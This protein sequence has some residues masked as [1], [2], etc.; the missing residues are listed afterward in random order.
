MKTSS[1]LG[2]LAAGI[3]TSSILLAGFLWLQAAASPRDLQTVE[4][5]EVWV[6]NMQELES[7]SPGFD[8]IPV[9]LEAEESKSLQTLKLE[10]K[11][12][13]EQALA[14]EQA[15]DFAGAG[16]AARR[17]VDLK[18]QVGRLA[19]PE[20]LTHEEPQWKLPDDLLRRA[21]WRATYPDSVTFKV[22]VGPAEFIL[23]H[24]AKRIV[25]TPN[26]KSQWVLFQYRE[27]RWIGKEKFLWVESEE[28]VGFAS[29]THSLA[30]HAVNPQNGFVGL[31]P[32]RSVLSRIFYTRWRQEGITRIEEM[33]MPKGRRHH[34]VF[35][36]SPED[37]KEFREWTNGAE[38]DVKLMKDLDANGEPEGAR[39]LKT[40]PRPPRKFRVA[41]HPYS[42]PPSK[43]DTWIEAA[44]GVPVRQ[45]LYD[46]QGNILSEVD[47]QEFQFGLP[48]DN[49]LFTVGPSAQNV[50]SLQELF[51][52]AFGAET[53]ARTELRKAK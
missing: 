45:I 29:S 51:K 6:S 8:N 16:E 11:Y 3:L 14:L 43:I 13:M 20:F 7:W 15:G 46:K 49:S 24:E 39:R 36:L 1:L 9:H 12:W 41:P 47:L 40:F 22:S 44:S 21:H 28:E 2:M 19:A 42:E 38:A 50:Q 53:R 27:E 10:A 32:R 33:D 18:E 31:G 23:V 52:E 5:V 35:E 25:P 26:P 34:V 48:M 37:Q 17:F 30:F 4:D